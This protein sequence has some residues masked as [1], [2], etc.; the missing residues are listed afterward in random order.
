MRAALSGEYNWQVPD[1]SRDKGTY[2]EVT[3]S[4]ASSRTRSG[5]AG[6]KIA[7][8][9]R[10]LGVS[11]VGKPKGERGWHEDPDCGAA[12]L[13]ARALERAI[14]PY[15]GPDQRRVSSAQNLSGERHDC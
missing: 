10:Q 15:T 13:P 8:V 6:I 1:S 7:A 14:R 12:R 11:V 5:G 4:R 2:S 9:A 3:R